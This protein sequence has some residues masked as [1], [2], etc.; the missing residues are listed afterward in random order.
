M[1]KYEDLIPIPSTHVRKQNKTNELVVDVCNPSSG[2]GETEGLLGLAGQ[3]D[4]RDQNPRSIPSCSGV[5]SVL[6]HCHPWVTH[7]G[8]QQLLL[9]HMPGL[10]PQNMSNTRRQAAELSLQ[11]T[12]FWSGRVG[13]AEP[14]R[15]SLTWLERVPGLCK[16]NPVGCR[17]RLSVQGPV[18]SMMKPRR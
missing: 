7:A 16:I 15:R 13:G 11:Q 3:P 6:S 4:K 1:L 12:R 14:Q 2:E 18:L 5:F 10:R 8:L 17:F 9:L